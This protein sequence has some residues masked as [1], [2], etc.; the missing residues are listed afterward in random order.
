MPPVLEENTNNS[1]TLRRH[2]D[3]VQGPKGTQHT[4]ATTTA[5]LRPGATNKSV[6]SHLPL[7][8]A[9]TQPDVPRCRCNKSER[10]LFRVDSGRRHSD[11]SQDR[12]HACHERIRTAHEHLPFG[13]V[14][15]F[16]LEHRSIQPALDC[17]KPR[18]ID[19]MVPVPPAVGGDSW[20]ACSGQDKPDT[21]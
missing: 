15:H 11:T 4:P 21:P 3:T 18:G 1:G 8:L 5:S 14:R 9:D 13:H 20:R 6:L 2:A 19:R 17:G 7:C 16:S 10:E 12:V